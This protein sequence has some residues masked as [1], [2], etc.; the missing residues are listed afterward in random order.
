MNKQ[1][2]GFGYGVKQYLVAG[3]LTLGFSTSTMAGS[4]EALETKAYVGLSITGFKMK[5]KT[6]V[7]GFL[8]GSE[9]FGGGTLRLGMPIHDYLSLE[10]R[11]SFSRKETYADTSSAR[12]NK[13]VSG[14]ILV[15]PTQGK[16]RPYALVGASNIDFTF[17]DE[18]GIAAKSRELSPA[19]GIG[20]ALYT[21][22][23]D[24]GLS[25]EYLHLA[26]SKFKY[27]VQK[28]KAKQKT[29]IGA[30]SISVLKH[31]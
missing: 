9:K 29:S 4:N 1:L 5:V 10:G 28:V 7:D 13:V 12:I 24:V 6:S 25:F 8:Y 31:F 27:E 17:K 21:R 18:L 2:V 11:Y 22:K 23:S 16:Y 14:L 26:E 15:G 19:L 30:L 20:L 3:L